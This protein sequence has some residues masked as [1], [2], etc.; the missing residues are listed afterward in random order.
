ME[1]ERDAESY[2]RKEIKK[3]GGMFLKWSSPGCD[4]V[5]D[6]IVL[7][8]YR[9]VI[10]VEVKARAGRLRPAQAY[11][12]RS[13]VRMGQ[14][15]CVVHGKAGAEAFIADLKRYV[16]SSGVYFADGGWQGLSDD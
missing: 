13:M 14:Q 15:V 6:R 2:L 9:N 16:I 3:M 12:I 5:P 10:F 4:G 11:M 8:P 7:L 1:R